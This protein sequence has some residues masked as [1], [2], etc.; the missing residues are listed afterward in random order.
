MRRA[1]LG[2]NISPSEKSVDVPIGVVAFMLVRVGQD[3]DPARFVVQLQHRQNLEAVHLLD[4]HAKD[5]EVWLHTLDLRVGV[6]VG[7]HEH[8]V[9][10]PGVERRLEQLQDFGA[11]VDDDY[12]LG[13]GSRR[14]TR[15]SKV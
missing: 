5:D 12:L 1:G 14:D 8:D 2:V 11:A 13:A 15:P 10:A 7:F 4:P 6:V 9:V 3:R